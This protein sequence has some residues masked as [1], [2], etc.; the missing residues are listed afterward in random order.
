MREHGDVE[1][2]LVVEVAVERALRDPARSATS[3]R[4]AGMKPSRKKTAR[5]ASR[6]RRRDSAFFCSRRGAASDLRARARGALT[7]GPARRG[8]VARCRRRRA[9]APA[10]PRARRPRARARAG[11]G[12]RARP[13]ARGS[14][15]PGVTTAPAPISAP[16]PIV[17]PSS[18]IAPIPTR[19]PSPTRQPWTTARW[20]TVTSSPSSQEKRSR[21]TCTTQPSWRLLRAP[22]RTACTSPRSTRAVPDARIRAD[23]HVADHDRAGRDPGVGMDARPHPRIGADDGA[24]LAR[25]AGVL[26]RLHR[27][28]SRR[29]RSP[30]SGRARRAW[31]GCSA[32]RSSG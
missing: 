19:A 6:M 26:R 3:S 2:G 14:L 1:L 22:T 10:A 25:D 29:R 7:A 30:R 12:C 20:P 31:S 17:A 24:G 11:P 23:L 16:A 13:S 8:D 21:V 28:R 4:F 9:P 15:L 32:R 27:L 18:T 5:A